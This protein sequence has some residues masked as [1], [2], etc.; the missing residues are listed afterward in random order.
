M[1]L[2]VHLLIRMKPGPY[3]MKLEG[4]AKSLTAQE[5]IYDKV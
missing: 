3:L 1:L 2:G 5:Y 4:I